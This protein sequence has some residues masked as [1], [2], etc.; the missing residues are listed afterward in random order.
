M[1]SAEACLTLHAASVCRPQATQTVDD[2]LAARAELL[3]RPEMSVNRR[4][5][6][7]LAA[8]D[9]RTPPLAAR[10]ARFRAEPEAAQRALADRAL[11]EL[12]AGRGAALDACSLLLYTA[13]SVDEHVLQAPVGWLAS[14]HGMSDRQHYALAQ[15]EGA[16]MALAVDLID[17]SLADGQAA[18]LVAAEKWPQPFP[19]CV[20]DGA[21]LADVGVALWLV[22][23]AAP[24]LALLASAQRSGTPFMRNIDSGLDTAALLD[25][26]SAL[27][28]ATLGE[29]GIAPASIHGWLEAGPDAAL[30]APLRA[31]CGVAPAYLGRPRSDDGYF[32]S[33]AG[34]ALCAAALDDIAAGVL[35]DGALLVSWGASLSGAVGVCVWQVRA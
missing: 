34:P 27:V 7:L 13:A 3:A 14:R 5:A 2:W 35:A 11:G 8:G 18:L 6:G 9:G 4:L 16:S 28:R 23:G 33:A 21:V 20:H 30:E 22:R 29:H 1:H 10:Q 12:L 15:L 17:A 32:C 31:R 24:G 25:A 26:A 19:R